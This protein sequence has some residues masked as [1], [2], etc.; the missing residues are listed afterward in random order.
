MCRHTQAT[1]RNKEREGKER[2]E[3]GDE[4]KAAR[5]AWREVDVC[6]RAKSQ[7]KVQKKKRDRKAGRR[8]ENFSLFIY[9][10]TPPH[11]FF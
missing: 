7:R 4:R 8:T 11:L 1:I 9:F 6:E 10:Y 3:E 2:E 5:R